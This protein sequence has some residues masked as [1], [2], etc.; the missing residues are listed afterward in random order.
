MRKMHKIK[1]KD[2]FAWIENQK[3]RGSD[4]NSDRVVWEAVTEIQSGIK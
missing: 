3:L 2:R 1:E 4:G